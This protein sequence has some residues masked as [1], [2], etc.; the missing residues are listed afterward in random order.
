MSIDN[1][2]CL[3]RPWYFASGKLIGLRMG[4]NS[5]ELGYVRFLDYK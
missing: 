1:C 5:R 3:V 4:H 2:N